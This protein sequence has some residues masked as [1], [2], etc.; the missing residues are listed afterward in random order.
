M[1]RSSADL[2]E[3]LDAIDLCYFDGHLEELDVSIGWMR[4]RDQAIPTRIGQYDFERKRIEIARNLADESV[5]RFYV[6]QIIYHEALHAI[7]G[8][9]HDRKFQLA[10]RQYLFTYEVGE[11]ERNTA[12]VPWP[13]APKGLR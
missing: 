10:E 9:E 5:P 6:M 13:A 11:W 12:G 4:A 3:Y 8:A 1:T 7:Y 2:R